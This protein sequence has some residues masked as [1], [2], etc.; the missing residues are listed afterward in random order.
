[1]HIGEE[2]DGTISGVTGFGIFVELDN[3]V[4]G[5]IRLADLD[6]TYVYDDKRCALFGQHKGK[7]FT[8]GDHIRISVKNA[9]VEAREIDFEYVSDGIA[10]KQ[11]EE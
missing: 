8:L 5:L 2:Y 4:E 9:N 10:E 7:I 1:M 6:D 3:T 11:I